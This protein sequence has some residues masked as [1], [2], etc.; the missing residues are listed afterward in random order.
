[1]RADFKQKG[2]R[3]PTTVGIRKLDFCPFV[4]FNL[5]AVQCLVLSQSTFVR[6]RQADSQSDGRTEGQTELRLPRPC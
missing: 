6:D 2:R 4:W 3:P 1:L 5:F